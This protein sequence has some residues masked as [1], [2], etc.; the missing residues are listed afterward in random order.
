MIDETDPRCHGAVTRDS[1]GVYHAWRDTRA[2]IWICSRSTYR[3]CLDVLLQDA[4]EQRQQMDALE[5]DEEMAEPAP[6]SM[7][8]EGGLRGRSTEDEPGPGRQMELFRRVEEAR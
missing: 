8:R 2:T 3:E 7:Q 5:R 4:E 6:E 1:D